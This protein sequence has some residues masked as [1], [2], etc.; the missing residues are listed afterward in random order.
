MSRNDDER[1]LPNDGLGTDDLHTDAASAFR[2]FTPKPPTTHQIILWNLQAFLFFSGQF[3]IETYWAMMMN[4]ATTLMSNDL[5][6]PNEICLAIW[7]GVPAASLIVGTYAG[8]L[9]INIGGTQEDRRRWCRFITMIVSAVL[10]VVA[11]MLFS[12]TPRLFDLNDPSNLV[13]SWTVAFV[14]FFASAFFANFLMM[15]FFAMMN[16][17]RERAVSHFGLPIWGAA[18]QLTVMTL[19][20][21]YSGTLGKVELFGI[22]SAFILVFTVV[23]FLSNHFW[24]PT[25][26][27]DLKYEK[28]ADEAKDSGDTVSC[29]T[30]SRNI[31]CGPWI[32][33]WN[34][35][36]EGGCSMALFITFSWLAFFFL[37]PNANEWFARAIRDAIP[38][39][40]EYD[41][42]LIDAS[43]LRFWQQVIQAAGA[44][45][46]GIFMICRERRSKQEASG[47]LL[48]IGKEKARFRVLTT[49]AF[50][51]MAVFTAG[52]F[53]AGFAGPESQS[54]AF[55]GFVLTG[56]GPVIIYPARELQRAFFDIKRK[57]GLKPPPT[58]TQS[59][60]LNIA[61]DTMVVNL[62]LV[63][64][65]ILAVVS[66]LLL[67]RLGYPL[68]IKIG[69]CAAGCCL[70][71]LIF[72]LTLCCA[73]D[74][75]Y[76]E[77]DDCCFCRT[78]KSK[79]YYEKVVSKPRSFHRIPN[80]PPT[81]MAKT[82]KRRIVFR[83]KEPHQA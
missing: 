23:S 78:G 67:V 65:Q 82:Q 59:E 38:S 56:F 57:P 42:A 34:Y 3:A 75:Q 48:I 43:I 52:M 50:C 29:A 27:V 45:T 15:P 4:F 54:L 35:L 61:Y 44:C 22:F 51:F 71:F 18:A 36:K 17:Y 70:I 63:F 40:P 76:S 9:V 10:T 2:P 6:A 30:T 62:F 68:L 37:M 28:I 21:K 25:L 58:A 33:L 49:V 73:N 80:N 69:A 12:A 72:V 74:L 79:V 32:N 5:R 24:P 60:K 20:G 64:G 83:S 16:D 11:S 81:T 39:E 55:W 19:V 41:S 8:S 13:H 26:P 53:M 77:M 47:S 66:S 14:S 7:L 1:V 46:F 31:L